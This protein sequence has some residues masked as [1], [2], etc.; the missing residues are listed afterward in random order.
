MLTTC[1]F[2]IFILMVLMNEIKLLLYRLILLVK[3]EGG[4]FVE[5]ALEARFH[6]GSPFYPCNRVLLS[7]KDGE[8]ILLSFLKKAI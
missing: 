4:G 8:V 5:T 6:I 3:G 1:L 2:C 7:I